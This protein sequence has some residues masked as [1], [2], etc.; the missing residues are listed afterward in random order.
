MGGAET[1]H[2]IGGLFSPADLRPRALHGLLVGLCPGR[3]QPS[4]ADA[5]A[6][7]PN[8]DTAE[9]RLPNPHGSSYSHENPSAHCVANADPDIFPRSD[10]VDGRV[11]APAAPRRPLFHPRW[12]PMAVAAI[13]RKP[14]TR[15]GASDG[16]WPG[17]GLHGCVRLPP[18]FPWSLEATTRQDGRRMADSLSLSITTSTTPAV[19]GSGSS[20]PQAPTW[21]LSSLSIPEKG[22]ISSATPISSWT[23]GSGSSCKARTFGGFASGML[24][25]GP[26]RVGF[27]RGSWL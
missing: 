9:N 27:E 11:A 5:V 23:D 25:S 16:F 8:A 22:F 19:S 2:S 17:E 26:M 15:R 20:Q 14:G 1:G 18:G 12:R 3:R 7:D 24:P 10:A 6:F 4:I 13:W 21:P